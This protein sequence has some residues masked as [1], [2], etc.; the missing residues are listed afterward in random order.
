MSFCHVIKKSSINE[1]FIYIDF[2]TM[3]KNIHL[4]THECQKGF[5]IF[6]RSELSC[7]YVYTEFQIDVSFRLEIKKSSPF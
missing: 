4:A 6:R 3:D 1:I 7:L 5:L 2:F